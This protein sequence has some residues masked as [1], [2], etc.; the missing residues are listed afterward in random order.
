MLQHQIIEVS[1][2]PYSFMVTMILGA[3]ANRFCIN[4]IPLNK[5]TITQHWPIPRYQD[6]FD[7]C[8]GSLWYSL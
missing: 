1:K 6:I 2:S 8:A 5:V 7:R 4:L 3:E